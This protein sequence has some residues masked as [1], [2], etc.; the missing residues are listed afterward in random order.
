MKQEKIQYL[1][2]TLDFNRK[3]LILIK[4]VTFIN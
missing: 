1:Q 2:E 3:K 4:L